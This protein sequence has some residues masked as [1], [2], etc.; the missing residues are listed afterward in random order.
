[1]L[2]L[3][4]NDIEERARAEAL[5]YGNRMLMYKI[6]YDILGDKQQAE[7]TVHESFVR[8]IKNLHKID[9][10]NC[11]RTRNYLVIICRNVAIDMYNKMKRISIVDY[12][13]DEILSD[14]SDDPLDILINKE[15]VER[16]T[17]A[18][19]ELKPIY[20]DVILLRYVHEF[21]C[22][23]IAEQ[24]CINVEAVKKRI[25]RGKKILAEKLEREGI[26]YE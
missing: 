20:R 6:A 26:R 22:E 2:F 16:L 23:E 7:D 19:M 14:E 24:L 1:M 15:S 5:Y 25:A 21:N 17:T 11:S 10:N 8:I 4:I 18:I 9:I 12:E 13:P 3:T